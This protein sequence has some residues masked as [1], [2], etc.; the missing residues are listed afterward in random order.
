M[1][2]D[3][4]VD[5]LAAEGTGPV[6][7]LA[8]TDLNATALVWPAGHEVAEHVNAALD[9]LL[10][11]LEGDATVAVDG[12]NHAVGAGHALLIPA[13]SARAIRAGAG[14]VRYLTVHRRRGPLQIE[15]AS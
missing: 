7:G 13:G 9:V 6:F 8:S 1:P 10:V 15:V 12:D 5:L 14:G 2:A 11:V 4:P 3:P